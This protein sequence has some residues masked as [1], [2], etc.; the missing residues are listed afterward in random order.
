MFNAELKTIFCFYMYTLH[1]SIFF[2]VAAAAAALLKGFFIR[3]D[4]K[5]IVQL[6]HSTEF[7]PR[8]LRW[9]SA[10]KLSCGASKTRKQSQINRSWPWGGAR[11]DEYRAQFVA[12]Q[13]TH[14]QYMGRTWVWPTGQLVLFS[15]H[16]LKLL[17][18]GWARRSSIEC[19]STNLDSHILG[20]TVLSPW[21]AWTSQVRLILANTD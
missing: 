4:H 1:P 17:L 6:C 3:V 11:L 5:L 7:C 15:I 18:H 21:A 14:L 12:W 2:V 20:H 13:A 8:S 10:W 19:L 9:G 16:K